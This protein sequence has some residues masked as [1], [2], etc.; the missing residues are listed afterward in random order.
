MDVIPVIDVACGQV[1]RA[2]RGDRTAYQPIVTPLAPS[3]EPADVARGLRALFP[4]RAL[5]VADLDGID[6][7]GRNIH[8]VPQLSQAL[9]RAEIWI[10]AGTASRGAAR[11]MLAAPVTTLVVGSESLET[12]GVWQEIAA[13]APSLVGQH[14]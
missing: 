10:D 5:Y 8:L 3:A 12:A 7:R 9:P 13:E 4:F 6:G 11:L 14:W 1:V 2:V